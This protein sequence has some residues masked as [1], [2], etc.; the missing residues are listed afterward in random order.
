MIWRW[1]VLI[2]AL[3]LPACGSG[4]SRDL[5]LRDATVSANATARTLET[6]QG[7]ALIMYRTEQELA[8]AGAQDRDAARS[9]VAVIRASW[10]P[11]WEAF[12]QARATYAALAALLAAVPRPESE[13]VQSAVTGQDRA[14]EKVTRE[15]SIARTRV[16]GGVQ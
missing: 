14:M 6:M 15:L 9:R 3:A 13:A 7:L 5:I 12:A 11:V 2:A 10:L 4:A 16:Q 1:L 8:V